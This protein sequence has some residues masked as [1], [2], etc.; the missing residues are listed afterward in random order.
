MLFPTCWHGEGFLGIFIDAFIARLPVVASAWSMNE[1]L[2]KDGK[3]GW[4]IP[5]HDASALA[6]VME[7][8]VRNREVL[9]VKARCCQETAKLYD[10]N[11]VINDKLLRQLGL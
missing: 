4:I 7:E 2:I 3:N 5:P 9:G 11:L 8:I 6:N 10:I 1:E